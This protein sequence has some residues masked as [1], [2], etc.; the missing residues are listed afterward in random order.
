MRKFALRIIL[1]LLPVPLTITPVPAATQL[2][3]AGAT[4][5]APL[6]QR[7]IAEFT[8]AHPGIQINYQGLGSGAG[9]KQFTQGL[10]TFG[11][12]DAAMSDEEI[13][14][15]KPGVV[16]IPAT[17]GSVVLAYN[18]PEVK[19]LK[20]S[21]EAYTGIFLGKVTRWND[22]AIVKA[23]PGVKLPDLDIAACERSDGSGTTF[24]FTQHLSA[25]S[26]EFQ[27]KVG[28]GTTVTWPVG[29]AGKGNDGVTA[30]I[31]QSPGAIGYV[32]YGYAV[33]SK[34][35]FA[36][37]ENKAGNYVK[38]TPESG[39]ATLSEAQFP[40]DVLRGWVP[41]PAGKEAYPISTFTWLLLYKT[42][43]DQAKWNA[44]KAFVN[45]GLTDGQ[46]L[47]NELGYIPLPKPVTD[48]GLEALN[49]IK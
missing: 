27:E 46:K 43:T 33:N 22:P 7:W 14:K 37:L 16:L 45:F 21:R 13:A 3:G 47:S 19:D 40:P 23:N 34:L 12:S 30:L 49:Q 48:K 5:P 4:F 25:I 38:A 41:D 32:E 1:S 24:V 18:L 31:K 6:Y 28:K 36:A 17:A 42:Y 15:V 20:L 26:L 10:V 44:L 9:I 2:Q 39:A 11:A 35:K 8:K 29:V